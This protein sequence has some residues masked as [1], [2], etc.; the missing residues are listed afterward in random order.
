MFKEEHSVSSVETSKQRNIDKQARH[1][2]KGEY[3]LKEQTPRLS[4]YIFSLYSKVYTQRNGI[5]YELSEKPE[6]DLRGRALHVH[7]PDLYP[8]YHM[9]PNAPPIWSQ[10]TTNLNMPR[11]ASH[12]FEYILFF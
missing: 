1:V 12:Q 8:W 5:K 9:A 11:I 10:S 3:G 6:C 2:F 7:D 4:L